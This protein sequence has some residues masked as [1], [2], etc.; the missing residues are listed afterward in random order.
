VDLLLNGVQTNGSTRSW[1][2]NLPNNDMVI[3]DA[4]IVMLGYTNKIF[5][6]AQK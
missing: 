1:Q 4:T 2:K 3:A 5:H 6:H